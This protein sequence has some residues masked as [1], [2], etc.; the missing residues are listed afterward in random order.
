MA[1]MQ[2]HQAVARQGQA[3]SKAAAPWTWI[4]RWRDADSLDTASKGLELR[5][6]LGLLSAW[7]TGFF[8][9]NF[10]FNNYTFF[11]V[12]RFLGRRLNSLCLVRR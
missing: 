12:V 11:F 3:A 10:V 9:L 8:Y 7:F 4:G 6:A 1:R 2:G 5:G